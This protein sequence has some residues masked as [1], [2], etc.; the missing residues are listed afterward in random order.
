MI[1]IL[2]AATGIAPGGLDMTLR[3]GADPHIGIGRGNGQGLD[4]RQGGGVADT[5]AAGIEVDEPAAQGFAAQARLAVFDVV[6]AGG[7]GGFVHGTGPVT[8]SVLWTARSAQQCHRFYLCHQLLA[9]VQA[10]LVGRVAGN[11]G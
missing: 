3:V 7:E 4:P 8:E 11:T 10:Q 9:V 1:A 6:Q 5:L 2:L